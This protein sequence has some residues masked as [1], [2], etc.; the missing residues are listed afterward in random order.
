MKT[1][2]EVPLNAS[3]QDLQTEEAEKGKTNPEQ[4]TTCKTQIERQ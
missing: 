2:N 4:F 3:E 1:A